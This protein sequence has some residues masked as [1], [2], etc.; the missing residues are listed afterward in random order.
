MSAKIGGYRMHQMAGAVPAWKN[1]VLTKA[2]AG[3]DGYTFVKLGK[4]SNEFELKT[5][6]LVGNLSDARRRQRD[7]ESLQG[8]FV[9]LETA[10][11]Q[12]YTG[13]LVHDVSCE[14]DPLILSTDGS[15][16]RI[17]ATWRLQRTQ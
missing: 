15:D 10:Q 7:Y 16:A 1:A 11:G 3:T 17:M 2:R 8:T 12:S 9:R 13:V 4:R 6:A 5:V 14:L